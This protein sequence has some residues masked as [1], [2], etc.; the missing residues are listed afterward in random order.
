MISKQKVSHLF[1]SNSFSVLSLLF[2]LILVVLVWGL[3]VLL[4]FVI[5]FHPFGFLDFWIFG[6]L[7]FWIFGF[8]DLGL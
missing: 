3:F 4:S 5:I 6:F 2:V 1:G 7:D 8:L